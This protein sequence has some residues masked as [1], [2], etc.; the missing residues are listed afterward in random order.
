MADAQLEPFV[1]RLRHL[2]PNVLLDFTVLLSLPLLS[3]ALPVHIVW[4]VRI[5]R[6]LALVVHIVLYR[7][8]RNA[9]L[10]RIALLARLVPIHAIHRLVH[11]AL[12]ALRVKAFVL[13]VPIARTRSLS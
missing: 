5:Q 4:P 1:Q 6:P 9:R 12:L 13:S 7:P 2:P 11:I 8:F 10:A 3:L